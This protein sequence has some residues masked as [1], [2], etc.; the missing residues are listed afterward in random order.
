MGPRPGQRPP[1]LQPVADTPD[2]EVYAAIGRPG[3]HARKPLSED[4]AVLHRLDGRRHPQ[5]RTTPFR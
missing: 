3:G 1:R 5:R 2:D 4:D